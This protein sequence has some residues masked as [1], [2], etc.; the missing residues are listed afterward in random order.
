[1]AA[2][3]VAFLAW[4]FIQISSEMIEGDTRSFD[5]VVLRQGQLAGRIRQR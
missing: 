2:L 4:A 3:G 5:M 1:M